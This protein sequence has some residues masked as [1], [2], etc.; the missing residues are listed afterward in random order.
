MHAYLFEWSCPQTRTEVRHWTSKSH[1]NHQNRLFQKLVSTSSDGCSLDTS[2]RCLSLDQYC[3]HQCSGR[4]DIPVLGSRRVAKE[5]ADSADIGPFSLAAQT[6]SEAKFQN[7]AQTERFV[8]VGHTWHQA[9]PL[10]GLHWRATPLNF[11]LLW[12][13]LLLWCAVLLAL[14]LTQRGRVTRRG[15]AV[16]NSFTS[17]PAVRPGPGKHRNVHRCAL[18]RVNPAFSLALF[19]RTKEILNYKVMRNHGRKL[20]LKRDR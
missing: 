7:N 8:D 1:I 18:F 12:H 3:T 11:L 14:A 17:L 10:V 2:L 9:N 5:V 15:L 20:F 6:L 19:I 4:V 16:W 13:I